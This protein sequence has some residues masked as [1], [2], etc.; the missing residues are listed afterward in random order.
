V[1]GTP[2]STFSAEENSKFAFDTSNT[3]MQPIAE[4][5]FEKEV[6]ECHL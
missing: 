2:S 4:G 1:K 3:L 6:E 5:E